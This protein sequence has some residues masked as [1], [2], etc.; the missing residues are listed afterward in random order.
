MCTICISASWQVTEHCICLPLWGTDMALCMYVC[1]FSKTIFF[2]AE[3]M[4]GQKQMVRAFIKMLEEREIWHTVIPSHTRS[5][6]IAFHYK[7]P[8][9][10]GS[11][12]HWAELNCLNLHYFIKFVPPVIYQNETY[13]CWWIAT[14]DERT[15]LSYISLSISIFYS[16][17]DYWTHACVNCQYVFG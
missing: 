3:G 8:L 9:R 11:H 4:K 15:T 12:F 17:S 10:K 7:L 16:F 5:R 14:N 1:I 6:V 2:G 13:S